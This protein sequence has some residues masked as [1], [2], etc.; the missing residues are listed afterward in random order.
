MASATIDSTSSPQ[1]IKWS[2]TTEPRLTKNSSTTVSST[3]SGMYWWLGTDS[4]P[5]GGGTAFSSGTS[6]AQGVRDQ[7]WSFA[8]SSSSGAKITLTVTGTGDDDVLK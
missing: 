8:S 7:T 4:Q 5:S 1:D 3:V 6:F 2:S